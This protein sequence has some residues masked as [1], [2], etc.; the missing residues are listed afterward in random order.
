MKEV[1]RLLVGLALVFAASRAALGQETPPPEPTPR[2]GEPATVDQR[3]EDLDQKIRI[4]QR[5]REIEAEAA[6][7]RK[8]TASQFTAGRE[9]FS[10]KSAD[11]D[12]LLRLRGY[13]QLDGRFFS[14]GTP[15]G[16]DTFLMRRVRPIFEAT[17]FKI[18]D[19]R[20]MPEIGR[21]SCRER[22]FGYV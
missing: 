22:V 3:L 15:T 2:P 14:G 10:W 9:G 6:E 12:F 4:L 1:R 18:F 5:Q 21:A 7:E 17:V 19:V 20:V 11:G 13:V 8:K 16:T